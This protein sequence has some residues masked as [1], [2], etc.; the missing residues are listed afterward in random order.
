[1][2][3]R[4]QASRNRKHTTAYLLTY[5]FFINL[6]SALMASGAS[7]ATYFATSRT[8]EYIV[9]AIE[10]RRT[11][12]TPSGRRYF[13]D[14][15]KIAALS[16]KAVFMAEG[17]IANKDPR[18]Q[19]FDGFRIADAAYRRAH[20]IGSLERT[21]ELW[22]AELAP[23]LSNIYPLYP[24][25][26]HQRHDNESVVGYFFGFDSND[27]L[28]AFQAKIIREGTSFNRL[29]LPI[30]NN[31]MTLL[32]PIELVLE[33]LR[34]QTDR[35]RIAQ[36]QLTRESAGKSPSEAEVIRMKALVQNIPAWADDHGS[37]GDIAQVILERGEQRWRWY[38]RPSFC[39]EN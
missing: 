30:R 21:A 7:H 16:P 24:D 5:G 3:Y 29:V 38:H 15:C 4:F 17:I 37:G 34:G 11:D 14:Q 31:Q 19:E 20:P 32:G 22:A 6:G 10:S 8:D 9:I 39:L 2:P 25:L 18:A 35:A 1:M 28:S 26:F 33:F 12:D 13:D 23:Y 36:S 27:S